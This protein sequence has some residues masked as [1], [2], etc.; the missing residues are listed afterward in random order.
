MLEMLCTINAA[1]INFLSTAKTLKTQAFPRQI[2]SRVASDLGDSQPAGLL[3][4]WFRKNRCHSEWVRK[5]GH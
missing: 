3:K 1:A 2:I 4:T 5:R